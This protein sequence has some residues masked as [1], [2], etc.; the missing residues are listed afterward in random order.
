[1]T[2][3]VNIDDLYKIADL[4]FNT[5][6]SNGFSLMYSHLHD[7]FNKCLDED[8]PKYLEENEFIID[9][10]IMDNGT[11]II[12]QF[13]FKNIKIKLPTCDSTNEP[14]YPMDARIKKLTY[15]VKLYG[16]VIQE[17]IIKDITSSIIKKT[18]VGEQEDTLIAFIPTMVKSKYC[19]ITNRKDNHLEC[20]YDS[21]GYFIINGNEKIVLSIE[22]LCDNKPLVFT[23]ME[24]G[25]KTYL[26]Q[27]NSKSYVHK[28]MLSQL[29]VIK[30][31]KYNLIIN[32]QIISEISVFILL[33]AL[34]LETD[35]DIINAIVYD[36]NDFHLINILKIFI[37]ESKIKNNINSQDEALLYLLPKVKILKKYNELE[38]DIK[39]AQKKKN[40]LDLLEKRLLPHLRSDILYKAY[41]LCYMINK[42]L[43]CYLNRKE[44][45]DRDNFAN[46]RVDT[47]GTL[48]DDLFT[49]S[50][51]KMLSECSKFFRNR[52]IEEAPINIINQIKPN[53]IL[54]GIRTTLMM[55]NWNMKK[56]VSIMLHRMSYLLAQSF[57]RRLDSPQIDMQSN[58]K[59]IK[60]RF[61]NVSQ[62]GFLCSVESPDGKHIGYTKNLTLIAS[63]SLRK[64]SQNEI[65]KKILKN[66]NIVDILDA[67]QTQF[68]NWTKVFINGE[69]IGLIE[70]LIGI[71]KELRDKK[72]NNMIDKTV[73][74]VGD[75]DN[76]ELRIYSDAGRLFRPVLRVVDNV[77]QLTKKDI[78]DISLSNTNIKKNKINTW[79]KLLSD[80]PH[81]I[82]YIDMEEA[83]YLMIAESHKNVKEMHDK[84]INSLEMKPSETIINRY[85]EQSYKK[86][87]H[88]EI[89]PSLLMGLIVSNIPFLNYNYGV[90][91]T[92]QY[93]QG[94]QAISIYL[95][96]HRERMDLCHV[97][98]HP[99]KPL[100]MTRTGKYV[101]GDILAS[102][103]NIIVAIAV[104][105]GYNQEDSIIMNE[106]AIQRGLF[107]TTYYKKYETEI[108]KNPMTSQDEKFMKPD[109]DIV[110]GMSYSNYDKLNEKGYVNEENTVSYGD[111]II[112]KCSPILPTEY[113][114]K[115]YKDNSI[116]YKH[117][118]KGIID[119][120]HTDIQ[121]NEGYEIKRIKVRSER[122]PK[123]GDK[124]CCYTED[125]EILTEEGWIPFRE[126]TY[127]HR[128]ASLR[129]NDILCYVTPTQ[130]QKYKIEEQKIYEINSIGIKL[131]VTLNHR[132]YIKY[133]D[134]TNFKIE[135]AKNILNKEV[136]FKKKC[137]S[138]AYG[139]INYNMEDTF[140]VLR[141]NNNIEKKLDTD[142]WIHFFGLFISMGLFYNGYVIFGFGT[143]NLSNNILENISHPSKVQNVVY[144]NMREIQLLYDNNIINLDTNIFIHNNNIICIL[145]SLLKKLELQFSLLYDDNNIII[146]IDD[147]YI[148][149][150]FKQLNFDNYNKYIP[151]YYLYMLSHY[152]KKL[153]FHIT[154][155][156]SSSNDIFYSVSKKLADTFQQLCLHAG[157]SSNIHNN[158]TN[159]YEHYKYVS[160]ISNND[161]TINSVTMEDTIIKYTGNVY[162]CTVPS[163][164]IYVRKEGC[165]IWC[166]NSRAGQKGIIG[167]VLPQCD[168]PI[169]EDGLIPDI[170]IN[171]NCIPGRMT[172]GQLI[173][174]L[175]GKFALY[176][177][178]HEID[179]TPFND[180]DINFV[181]DEIN[182]LGHSGDCCEYLYNGM[183]GVKM[184]SKIF[185][186]PVYY[187]RLK[188]LVADKIHSRAR[189]P[190]TILTRQPP[191]GRTLDGGLRLGE[192]ER[193]CIL[194]NG[195]S[196][197]LKEKMVDN[198][199]IF[200][201]QVCD[202]CGLIAQRL[203]RNNLKY[204]P[205]NND[206]FGCKACNNKTH[207][208]K[209][210]CPYAMKLM[211]QEL[212]SMNIVPRIRTIKYN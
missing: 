38:N 174:T 54:S 8:I 130:I 131:S 159:I 125:H 84:M 12:H 187:Q 193:D 56:G 173:E 59:S 123:V 107:T 58:S 166:G 132:M 91:N 33:R 97:I 177:G 165:P 118:E 29:T 22:R 138:N 104:F 53:T 146:L 103:E 185:I 34:G 31:K 50:F 137:N 26:V 199:D 133:K 98:R 162:C 60:P 119:K 83:P 145:I 127:E 147:E 155:C 183:T 164:I 61:Y 24:T 43:Q 144:K 46:K 74:I 88:C 73:G 192:M 204:Y 19:N 71:E 75:I 111:A 109:E 52:N 129:D 168:M 100:V 67:S 4:Y 180:I 208:S 121:N 102:G 76:N 45:D 15:M 154:S 41:Y 179:G 21:G 96:N 181:M 48:L 149:T 176:R 150:Y 30:I 117:F 124:F 190:K 207:I 201:F 89:H 128:V 55:G 196:I 64:E 211:L 68:C 206:V 198:S 134:H 178:I 156:F 1:M 200:C 110:M 169:T 70:D 32:I 163:G 141:N 25:V 188:Q 17:K 93:V 197:F 172:I 95:S 139:I 87:S 18:I 171:P 114:K 62:N 57:L 6:V 189:G 212:I 14:I 9:E 81:I 42:L 39:N 157:C 153:L 66:N 28:D 10:K 20:N 203:I 78:E 35:E 148:A 194:C 135:F 13:R 160:F 3:D 49:K 186:G 140:F 99:Q 63:I 142:N 90:R 120:I 27:I 136:T 36:R 44:I 80:K 106:T 182:K 151:S 126:L 195:C 23:K 143:S 112:G 16:Y 122:I 72:I 105:N 69:W 184:K 209:I 191:E 101:Y 158:Y 7:H 51:K 11:I 115:I 37:E 113:N 40:L 65:I 85:D 108:K 92:F 94:K 175:T 170:I 116:I 210:I 5:K 79:F 202:K 77:I 167:C 82:D 205:T 161:Y 86:Y 2:N 152:R 47:V